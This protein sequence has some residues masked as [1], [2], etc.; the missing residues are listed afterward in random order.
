MYRDVKNLL[1]NEL[2]PERYSLDMETDSTA[3]LRIKNPIERFYVY[4]SGNVDKQSVYQGAVR[5]RML[6]ESICQSVHD[7]DSCELMKD[8]Y[9][10]LWAEAIADSETSMIDGQHGDT[11]TSLQHSLNSSIR[12]IETE[13]E[14]QRR[15]RKRIS[16]AYQIELLSSTSDFL[17]RTGKIKGLDSFAVLYHT[18]GNMIPVPPMFNAS[19]SN[20]GAD[21]Y[22]DV[23]LM[24]IKEW[25]DSRDRATLAAL[26]HKKEESDQAVET[27]EKWLTWFGS[28]NGFLEKNYLNDFV[29]RNNE[30]IP[31]KPNT[32]HDIESFYET[33]SDL[34]AKRGQ[35]LIGELKKR[36]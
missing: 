35:R 1:E 2:A 22:W 17:A 11:M 3:Y 5:Y 15:G 34:I 24:K 20:F 36:V 10:S 8:V 9:K 25:Y 26:L 23:T 31:F 27:C 28:W 14:R 12:L 16:L 18:I 13:E 32:A 19:R 21:D 4:K 6:N 29:D 33:C 30:P 7:C